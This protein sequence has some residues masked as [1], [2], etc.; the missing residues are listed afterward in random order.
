M[1]RIRVYIKP[2]VSEGVYADDFIE[3]SKDVIEVGSISK[4]LDNSTYDIGIFKN[5]G[6]TIRLRND[7]GRYSTAEQSTS[8]FRDKRLDSIIKVTW[9]IQPHPLLAG[10]FSCQPY[11]IGEE[12]TVFE[13]LLTEASSTSDIKDQF[14]EFRVSGYE[15]LIEQIETPYASISN[16]D[17]FSEVI[18]TCLNQAKLTDYVTVS[19]ANIDCAVDEAIDDKSSLEDTTVKEALSGS[20]LLLASSSVLYIE[21]N[22][23]YVQ[24][25]DA[26]VDT[27]FTF[28]G[29]AAINGNENIVNISD[30]RDGINKVFNF[31]Q[32]T[33]TTIT[34]TLSSSVLKYGVRKRDVA[35]ELISDSSTSKINNILEE[36]RDDF[37]NPKREF[38]LE[39]MISYDTLS[40]NL[41]DRV[42]VDYPTTYL[43]SNENPIPRWGQGSTTWGDF[44]WPTGQYSLTINPIDSFKIIG[45]KINIKN[46]TIEFQLRE[47]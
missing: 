21:D 20:D 47:V 43:S 39:T 26:T 38:W 40:L 18:L 2:F 12:V 13:G 44:V 16:G 30:Y 34:S 28:Y 36:I 5:S 6:M 37:A 19:G 27:K 31:L 35:T 9:S 15:S 25:R 24:N 1:S 23:L 7:H 8:I 11:N 32:W 33:D 4:S 14:I 3:I 45:K 17:L 22:V 42:S 41:K 29:Q 46:D 10:F